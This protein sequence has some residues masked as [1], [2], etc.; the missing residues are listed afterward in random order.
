MKLNELIHE[1]T[2]K[3]FLNRTFWAPNYKGDKVLVFED[4]RKKGEPEIWEMDK[5]KKYLDILPKELNNPNTINLIEPLAKSEL[6]KIESEDR[7]VWVDS[8]SGDIKHKFEQK[9]KNCCVEQME[10]EEK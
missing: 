10:C 4:S 9:S 5:A 2:A 3:E 1:E 8:V 6:I 7:L